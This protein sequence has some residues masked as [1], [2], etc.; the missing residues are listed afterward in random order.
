MIRKNSTYLPG[1][2][3]QLVGGARH[4]VA[5]ALPETGNFE[6]NVLRTLSRN[7]SPLVVRVLR[8][9]QAE[10]AWQPWLQ[11]PHKRVDARM[12]E[13]ELRRLLVVDGAV[14]LVQAP[15]DAPDGQ[16]T[17]V[18]DAAAVRVLEL[19][20]AAAWSRG[21]GIADHLRFSPRM[22]TDMT[23]G[24]LEL[25]RDGNT[26]ETAARKMNVSLRTYRRHVAEIMREL[27]AT[28]RFEAGARAVELGILAPGLTDRAHKRAHPGP[29]HPAESLS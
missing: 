6:K 9:E 14:A 28:S 8:G 10:Q 19:H 20:F 5:V 17:V 3:E 15:T 23:R 27:D 16:L 7:A 24:I 1:A 2:L 29:W 18:N 13:G 21:R 12:N 22:R 26:D 25:L 11:L 4:T